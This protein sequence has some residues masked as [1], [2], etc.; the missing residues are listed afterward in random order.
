M[1]RVGRIHYEGSKQAVPKYEGYA[2]VVVLTKSSAYGSLGPYELRT[3]QNQIMENIWQF[4]KIYP[5]VPNIE[6]PYTR[7]NR[8]IVWSWPAEQHWDHMTQEPTPAYW[9]WRH[10][11]INN[12]TAVRYPVGMKYR[13]TCLGAFAPTMDEL[14]ST[15]PTIG[16][17]RVQDRLD[18]VQA[19][20]HIYEPL[21]MDLVRR[22]RQYGEL[23]D[24]LESGEKL[25]ICE[26]DGPHQESVQYYQETYGMEQDFIQQHSM[27][28]T[29]LSLQ[30]MLN[31]PK[32]AYGHGYCL[33]KALLQDLSPEN[34]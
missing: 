2:P 14:S 1:I 15:A 19:R 8:K 21:Y 31:D 13:H 9:R 5:V 30:V 29:P 28:A 16:Q 25:L 20:K 4:S 23:L 7:W 34:M 33:A 6:V 17:V 11:G 27:L 22:Q 18:Y 26:T 12:D 3:A 32:H 10:D 24:R